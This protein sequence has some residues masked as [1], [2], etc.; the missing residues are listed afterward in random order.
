MLHQTWSWVKV[1]SHENHNWIL[2]GLQCNKLVVVS[3]SRK[4]GNTET[5]CFML[6]LV[7]ATMKS[8]LLYTGF[9]YYWLSCCY[10]PFR[11]EFGWTGLWLTRQRPTFWFGSR[12]IVPPTSER[13][14]NRR[15]V[16]QVAAS[17]PVTPDVYLSLFTKPHNHP[18]TLLY[19]FTFQP[20]RSFSQLSY[21]FISS[22]ESCIVS[23]RHTCYI[24][25]H[26][27]KIQE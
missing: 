18:T 13:S 7:S 21:L 14:P 9:Y 16:K 17:P 22:L 2:P 23:G 19:L 26:T 1:K 27:H 24:Y 20:T 6:G 4:F 10:R 15:Q 5:F 25:T 8:R 12:S 3:T 11:T